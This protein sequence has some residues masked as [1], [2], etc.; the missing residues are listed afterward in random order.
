MGMSGFLWDPITNMWDAEPEVWDQLIQAKPAAAEL[1]TM[2]I[3]NYDK[4]IILYG[5]DR[6]TGKHAETGPDML[7]RGARKNLKRS[8][9]SSL[10][11]DEVDE[12]I[13]VNVASL[14]NT[15]EHG[16]D[17]Q[18]QPT[19]GEPTSSSYLETLTPIRNKKSKHDHLDGMAD[20]LR[21]GM[22]NLSNAINRLSTM[23]PIPANEIW[24]M[25]KEM[26]LE[27]HLSNKA[28]I[29]LCKNADMCRTLMG[30][31]QEDRKILLLTMMSPED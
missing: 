12:M 5:K 2:S 6:D 23:P 9:T 11:I 29:V 8:S 15:E 24:Q 25:V 31:P 4:L 22:D 27:R 14:E 10:T 21:G 16:Q 7:K 17:K 3:R 28:Y 18:N 1:R 13:S 30:C 19:N 20:M 26:N